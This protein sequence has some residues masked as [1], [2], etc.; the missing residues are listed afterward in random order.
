MTNTVT[1]NGVVTGQCRCVLTSLQPGY[2]FD[3]GGEVTYIEP[4][5][6]ELAKQRG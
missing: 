4:E 2:G 3:E 5:H 1:V 6:D